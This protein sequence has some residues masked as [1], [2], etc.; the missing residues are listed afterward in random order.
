LL[1]LIIPDLIGKYE[2]VHQCGDKN[3]KAI[4]A[5]VK[6]QLKDDVAK[7]S[8]HL[9]STLSEEEMA[10]AYQLASVII[11]RAGS[12]AI[13]EIAAS[14]KPSILVPY[15]DA[16][17]DHQS[18]NAKIYKETGAAL[19]LRGRNIMPHMLI[20]LIDKI[21]SNPEQSQKMSEA[22]REFAKPDAASKIAEEILILARS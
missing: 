10:S 2:I 13:F 7:E 20:G 12:G 4:S 19:V 1:L 5:G 22:A 16:A 9:Y 15:L 21:I 8:Y 18:E 3:F 11:S 14:G 6:L 17:G